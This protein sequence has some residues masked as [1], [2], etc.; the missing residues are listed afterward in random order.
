MEPGFSPDGSVRIDWEEFDDRMSRVIYSS[1][2]RWV[3]SGKPILEMGSDWD[4]S[5]E[6]LGNGNALLMHFRRYAAGGN[7]SV[8]VDPANGVFRIG[9]EAG[10]AEPLARIHPRIEEKIEKTVRLRA[11][12]P[13]PNFGPRWNSL[14][15]AILYC[16][17][18]LIVMAIGVWATDRRDKPPTPSP[19]IIRTIPTP[20]FQRLNIPTPHGS[21]SRSSPE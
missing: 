21:P 14:I 8:M 9:G 2:I 1:Q 18:I 5:V 7:V 19:K 15:D 10:T 12:I 16:L 20:K 3:A 11:E 6:W 13:L 4:G 17:L